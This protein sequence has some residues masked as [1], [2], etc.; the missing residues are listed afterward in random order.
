MSSE[1]NHLQGSFAQILKK[2]K[3]IELIK[4]LANNDCFPEMILKMK[5]IKGYDL[6]LGNSNVLFLELV[7]SYY[8]SKEDPELK[9]R[10]LLL[11]NELIKIYYSLLK[12][13]FIDQESLSLLGQSG[14]F[15][16]LLQIMAQNGVL[17]EISP[18]ERI[19]KN[20]PYKITITSLSKYLGVKKEYYL[21]FKKNQVNLNS[22]CEKNKEQVSIAYDFK[23]EQKKQTTTKICNLYK[24]I[25]G[26]LRMSKKIATCKIC[27][28]S[29]A[30]TTLPKNPKHFICEECDSLLRIF[31]SSS[32]STFKSIVQKYKRQKL[33]GRLS[34]NISYELCANVKS[35]LQQ[36]V[37]SNVSNIFGVEDS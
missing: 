31:A 29:Y 17:M 19:R 9:K 6:G 27:D 21:Y 18:L 26:W 15:A 3:T 4:F 11:T 25:A 1:I 28:R 35:E 12:V 36:Q 5:P 16:K 24:K 30:M 2:D 33:K 34:K 7:S 37:K 32:N 23:Y 10:T 20:I 22:C 13:N 14:L 8:T